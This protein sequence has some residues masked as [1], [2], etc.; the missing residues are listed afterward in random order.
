M[1]TETTVSV[2]IENLSDRYAA[3]ALQGPAA[4][5]FFDFSAA[6]PHFHIQRHQVFGKECWVA[7]TGYTGEDGFEL[8]CEAVDVPHLWRMLLD[9]GRQFGIQPGGLGARD[10][11]RLEV[12]CPFHGND[13]NGETRPLAAGLGR[14][15]P[16]P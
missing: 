13:L 3:L 1:N 2:V 8:F 10:T 5:K 9:K 15:L 14:F 12:G 6:L 11:L 4:G 7:R 16:L